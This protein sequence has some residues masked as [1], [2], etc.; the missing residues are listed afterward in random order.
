[1]G[2]K[3]LGETFDIH[4]GG[5]DLQATHH[6]NEIA[7]SQACNHKS[8]V[9]Y[10]VHTNMLTVN[11]VRMSKSAGNG[12]LPNELFTG[13]H[14]LLERGYSP[15]A[16]R[17][18]MLQAHYRSTL[19]FSNEALQAAE[20]GLQRLMSANRMLN[21]IKPAAKS[22]VNVS[23][24]SKRAF[25][26]LNDDFNSP[27]A[28]AVLFDWVRNINSATEGKVELTAEDIEKLTS[29]FR[30]IIFDILGLTDEQEDSGGQAAL[31]GKLI[32]MLLNMRLDAKTKKDFA[33]SDTIRN[34]LTEMGVTVK[35]RKDGFDWEING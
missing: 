4:G 12:F 22:S 1:M 21:R 33:T 14:P 31:T 17:F 24:L 5:M 9:N 13:N 34:Q 7:Q 30:H 3:Y 28:I 29:D 15:M 11:G 23:D 2:R 35:D 18:F 32:E 26:A 27:I 16:V 6:T 8:P 20:K 19:D 10:W 25:E